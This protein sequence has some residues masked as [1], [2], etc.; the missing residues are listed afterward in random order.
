M[1][2][3]AEFSAIAVIFAVA[4]IAVVVGAVTPATGHHGEPHP[5]RA[6]A[7]VANAPA[8]GT[9]AG[10]VGPYGYGPGAAPAMGIGPGYNAANPMP[11]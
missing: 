5:D 3:V 2:K 8:P 6:P 1:R 11:H 9:F 4:V 7:K 10:K